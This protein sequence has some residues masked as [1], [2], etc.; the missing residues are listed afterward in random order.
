MFLCVTLLLHL[1]YLALC[2]IV[3]GVS[4]GNEKLY[5]SCSR[6]EKGNTTSSNG[7][8]NGNCYFDNVNGI[9]RDKGKCICEG[10]VEGKDK[11][12]VVDDTLRCRI[13]VH[14]KT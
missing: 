11:A 12:K 13:T 2:I 1:K 3:S 14:V 4:C 7:W 10:K 5:P 9:C 8:C 6:C